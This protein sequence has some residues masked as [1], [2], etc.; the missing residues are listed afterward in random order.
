M[1]S[2]FLTRSFHSSSSF[3][4]GGIRCSLPHF[5]Y[6]H[7][8]FHAGS[9]STGALAT[10]HVVWQVWPNLLL[11]KLGDWVNYVIVLLVSCPKEQNPT[12]YLH[13]CFLYMTG[14]QG[15]LCPWKSMGWWHDKYYGEREDLEPGAK[16][17]YRYK[18]LFHSY[19][20]SEGLK[21]VQLNPSTTQCIDY[22]VLC[23]ITWK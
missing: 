2:L 11:W 12:L 9:L 10:G 19:T 17:P 13:I 16:V 15:I 7:D 8:A 14:G 20:S 5:S 22:L 18:G 1:E 23:N 4:V 21:S 3:H 6:K